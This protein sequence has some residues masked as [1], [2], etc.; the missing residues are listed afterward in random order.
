MGLKN[1]SSA[2]LGLPE[3]VDIVKSFQGQN[4]VWITFDGV[5]VN[6]VKGPDLRLSAYGWDR[7]PGLPEAKYLASVSV[8]CMEKRLV[9]ME[10]VLLYLLFA[11]D[12]QLASHAFQE[13]SKNGLP[14][15]PQ[16]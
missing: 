15:P 9:T 5:L 6:G 4:G 3:L 13:V 12:A 16:N 14:S 11:L 1:G 10:A 7:D 2:I 8:R